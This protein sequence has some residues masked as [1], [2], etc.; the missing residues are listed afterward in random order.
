MKRF[1]PSYRTFFT[2]KRIRSLVVGIILLVLASIFQSFAASYAMR[3]STQFVGD[4]FLEHLPI[5]NVNPIIIEGAF[6]AILFSTILLLLKPAHLIFALKAIAI[7]IM[8]RAFMISVTHLGVY[9]GTTVPD[10]GFFDGIYSALNLQAGYFFS[11]HTGLPILMALIF[12]NERL[13]RYCF[14]ALATVFGIAVLLAH[15]HYSIDVFAAP[16]MTY[17]IYKLAQYLFSED[18]EL[19]TA[20]EKSVIPL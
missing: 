16:F 12:W 14:L 10:P 3:R 15:V 4:F 2:R 9:P 11:G 18:Y 17:S 6:F 13:W 7:F 1:L 20:A 8:T 19:I 5:I